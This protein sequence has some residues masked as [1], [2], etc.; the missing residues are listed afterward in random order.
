[1]PFEDPRPEGLD[2]VVWACAGLAI[3]LGI[4]ILICCALAIHVRAAPPPDADPQ[5]HAWFETQHSV[6]G[7]WCCNVAD[8][9]VLTDNDWRHAGGHYEV[10]IAGQW[11]PVPPDAIRDPAGG[12]NPMNG[13]IV[14]YRQSGEDVRIFCFAPGFEY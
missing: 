7:A 9:F 8:G 14:W 11:Q 12:R 6:A 3:L 13:A 1:M 2:R 5:L 10:R 4:L